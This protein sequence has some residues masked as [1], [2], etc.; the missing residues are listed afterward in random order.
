MAGPGS[1]TAPIHDDGPSR[2]PGARTEDGAGRPARDRKTKERPAG[3]YQQVRVFR[4]G[5]LQNDVV[6]SRHQF[7]LAFAD[8]YGPCDGVGDDGMGADQRD[9][10]GLASCGPAQL[11][12]AE[13]VAPRAWFDANRLTG[14]VGGK[15][16]TGFGHGEI[17]DRPFHPPPAL[18]ESRQRLRGGGE[19]AQLDGD[20]RRDVAAVAD[21]PDFAGLG[22]QGGHGAPTQIEDGTVGDHDTLVGQ[23]DTGAHVDG[24]DR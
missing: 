19:V 3:G 12:F 5:L 20:A 13:G 16:G 9:R 24:I 7:G 14:H 2:C 21:R 6:L 11:R 4:A 18:G 22:I 17:G 10:N 23:G 8:L 1:E 15:H